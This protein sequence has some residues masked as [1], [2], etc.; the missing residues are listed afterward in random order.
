MSHRRRRINHGGTSFLPSSLSKVTAWLRRGE[1]DTGNV[2]SW[3][4]ML[5]SNHAVQTVDARRPVG[6]A[7]GS[8]TYAT[9]KAM[10]WPLN[11]TNNHTAI[12][13]C[14]FWYDQ[15]VSA[16]ETLF[17]IYNG[18]NGASAR[19]LFVQTNTSRRLTFGVYDAGAGLRQAMTNT[20]VLP[21]A[22]TPGFIRVEYD[23]SQSGDNKFKLF[24]NEV[25]ATNNMSG[26]GTAPTE[27]NAPTGNAIFGNLNDGVASTAYNGFLYRNFYLGNGLLTAAEGAALMNFEPGV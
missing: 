6:G 10:V 7:D 24:V 19:K 12:W 20:S 22:G 23:G 8:M 11:G 2:A 1:V 9:N 3:T 26:A 18:T 15:P 25:L 21:A 27:L 17:A 13:W 4:S 16:L 5:D 14:A